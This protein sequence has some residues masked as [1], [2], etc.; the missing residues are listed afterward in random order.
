MRHALCYLAVI[1]VLLALIEFLYIF[2]KKPEADRAWLPEQSQTAYALDTGSL[3]TI[4]NV[5]DWTY[6]TSTPRSTTWS[7]ATINPKEI[8]RVWFLIEPFS[9]WEAV[10]HTFLSFELADGR[11]YSFSVEARRETHETYSAIK[12]AFREYELSY[13]WGTERDFITRR[14]LFL[15]H[16]LR[17][18]P[19]DLDP[20][21]SQTLFRSLIAETNKLAEEPRF[22]NTLSANCTN[23]LAKIVNR[24]Y[25]GTL[26]LHH[27]WYLTGYADQY[28][29]EVGLIPTKGS[30]EDTM[31]AHDITKHKAELEA[32][33]TS[34]AQDFSA[35]LRTLVP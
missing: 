9:D 31:A 7:T 14:L 15:D 16:P 4:F 3:I 26:P 30:V 32:L 19:L 2:T 35:Y 5:R 17:L 10:G 25:P 6:G 11:V 24:Y 29:M 21:A 22:Y 33:A 34:P 20:A 23:V 8:V 13:Q 28:L 18:Y 1:I 27:A 12:G